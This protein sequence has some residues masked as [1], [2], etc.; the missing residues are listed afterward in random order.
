VRLPCVS[1]WLLPSLLLAL[2]ACD[3]PQREATQGER[4]EVRFSYRRSCFFGCPLEQPLL[5]GT[6]EEI[7]LSNRGSGDGVS[8]ESSDAQVASFALVRTCYCQAGQREDDR[9]EVDE[10][11]RC[12]GARTKVCEANV[13]VL[14]HAEGDAQLSLLDE[15]GALIDRSVVHVREAASARF[16]DDQGHDVES[17][18]LAKGEGRGLSLKLYDHAGQRLLAPEGVRW[19][20]GSADV[21][22][23][24]AWLIGA[25]SE[26]DAGS[27]VTVE[28]VAQGA[29]ELAIAVPGLEAS[30]SLQVR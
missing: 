25:G 14:A 28:A 22:R 11:A 10:E 12:D 5:A 9:V 30:I 16:W 18:Q 4:G 2:V 21:A 27:S 23:V 24:S 13:Q 1:A 19:T 15:H 8:A 6:R 7:S 29:T 3:A 26:L 20:S 17:L